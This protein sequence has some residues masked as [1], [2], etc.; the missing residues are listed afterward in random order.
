MSKV[1]D[2]GPELVINAGFVEAKDYAASTLSAAPQPPIAD[3][4]VPRPA[5]TGSTAFLM[6]IAAQK[7][8]IER[9]SRELDE[10]RAERD[11]LSKELLTPRVYSRLVE[12]LRSDPIK[13]AAQAFT[14]SI[15]RQIAYAL[16]MDV[17]PLIKRARAGEEALRSAAD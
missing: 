1:E 5:I 14:A 2:G 16:E 9:L 8:E 6:E 15:E 13:P 3:D 12:W 4:Q 17:V 7:A 11:S 10:A